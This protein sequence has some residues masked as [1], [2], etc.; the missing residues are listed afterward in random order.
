MW[1]LLSSYL[2]SSKRVFF[3]WVGANF[4]PTDSL[5]EPSHHH[6]H[7]L[8]TVFQT[9]KRFHSEGKQIFTGV[10]LWQGVQ[11]AL[12]RGWNDSQAVCKEDSTLL[13]PVDTHQLPVPLSLEETDRHWCL[14]PLLLPQGLRLSPLVDR[15]QGPVHGCPGL[16][17]NNIVYYLFNAIF[18]NHFKKWYLCLSTCR[19]WPP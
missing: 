1:Y 18:F 14:C 3:W 12:W 17:E 15:P 4:K 5:W 10:S 16:Y 9:M 13:N 8:N 11:Q 6:V 2:K 19:L 7:S